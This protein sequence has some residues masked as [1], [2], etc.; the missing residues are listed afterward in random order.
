MCQYPSN[1]EVIAIEKVYKAKTA[2]SAY[3]KALNLLCDR[4]VLKHRKDLGREYYEGDV[5]T[6]RE[7]LHNCIVDDE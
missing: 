5:N 1:S 3:I 2:E 7:V 6:I 4:G